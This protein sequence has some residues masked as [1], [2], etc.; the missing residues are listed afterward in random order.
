MSTQDGVRLSRLAGAL[1]LAG[2]HRFFL[3]GQTKEPCDWARVGF[4]APAELEPGSNGVRLLQPATDTP[5]VSGDVLDVTAPGMSVEDIATVLANRFLIRRNASV[6]ERLWRI[7]TG[8]S[9]ENETVVDTHAAWLLVM[10]ERVWDVV[11]DAALRC[12]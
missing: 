8:V 4:V 6:S 11:R 9:E 1:L 10:P 5:I 2:D 3:I 12:L 7:V